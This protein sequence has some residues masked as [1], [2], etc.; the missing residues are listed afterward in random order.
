MQRDSD[1]DANPSGTQEEDQMLKPA[2]GKK[3]KKKKSSKTPVIVP[4][5]G[6]DVGR[7]SVVAPPPAQNKKNQVLQNR[8][9][10][11]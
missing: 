6:G 8:V 2:E 9:Q 1:S 5:N 4:A 7:V 10:I 3:P 11:V